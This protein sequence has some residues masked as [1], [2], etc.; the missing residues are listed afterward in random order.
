MDK[1][2]LIT[3]AEIDLSAVTHNVQ[4][5]RGRVG[6]DVQI[7]AVVKAN[8]YGHGAVEVAKAVLAGGANQLGVASADEGLQLRYAGVKAPI[9]VL[10]PISPGE[11][12]TV[13]RAGL[14][15]TLY[16][17]SL[18][19]AVSDA[20]AK[21]GTPIL[22]HLKVDTGMGRQGLLPEEVVDFVKKLN[23]MPNLLLQGIFTHLASADAKDKSYTLFQIKRFSEVLAALKKNSLTVPLM[24][25]ANSAAICDYPEIFYNMVRPGLAIYGL[26]PSSEV[27]RAI[28]LRPA[29]TLKSRIIRLKTMPA[30]SSISYGCTYRTKKEARIATVAI[31]YGDGYSRS[32]SNKGTMLVRGQRAPVVGRVCMDTCMIDVTPIS[33]VQLGDEV[34]IIGAQGQETITVEEVAASIGTINYEVVTAVSARV[35]RV[36]TNQGKV[37]KIQRLA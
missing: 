9:L 34:V 18:A 25:V 2:S 16:D 31:G 32:H 29:M 8:A 37:V 14:M 6:P 27:S 3:W 23:S 21:G 1:S 7:M 30:G 35:P 11:V 17:L 15:V 26:Y 22:V 33:E 24:H 12:S 4:E 28:N 10:F 5:I 19:R 13:M 36:Y 20:A